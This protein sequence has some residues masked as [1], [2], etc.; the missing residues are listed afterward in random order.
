[1]SAISKILEGHQSIPSKKKNGEAAVTLVDGPFEGL[2]ISHSTA[3]AQAGYITQEIVGAHLITHPHL[4]HI[5]GF[6]V[7]TSAFGAKYPKTLAGL[8]Y[9]IEAFKTHIFN[10]VIWPNLSDENG[11]V[12]LVTYMRLVE[13]GSSALG[14]GDAI[15]YIEVVRGLGIKSFSV[16]HGNCMENHRH[17]GSSLSISQ[18]DPLPSPRGRALSTHS[19]LKSPARAD[20]TVSLTPSEL[21]REHDRVQQL[22]KDPDLVCVVDSSAYFI[23]DAATGREVLIFGDVEP[24]ALS[25]SPRNHIVWAEAAPK[26]VDG[27]LKAIFIEC[28]FD[29][30]QKDNM[31]YG[32]LAPRWMIVEMKNLAD[33]VRRVRD[34]PD[35][36][37][38][39]RNSGTTVPYRRNSKWP[40]GPVGD[41]SPSISPRTA[42]H[43][44]D[45][46]NGSHNGSHNGKNETVEFEEDGDMYP[47]SPHPLKGLKV[48]I[49][50]MKEK[51][52]D[53]PLVGEIILKELTKHEEEAKTGCEFVISK[54]GEAMYF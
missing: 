17:R 33:A 19:Q 25:L 16:S 5:S 45:F 2:Q 50:H 52:N 3:T 36:K 1:M 53:G 20:S 23:R 28:S 43:R 51:L 18:Q 12:G 9:T 22:R 13:G 31:L 24:D 8:P 26:I 11:G 47:P 4:D 40:G 7:N 38:R 32:H 48:V 41:L 44:H 6:V 10:N 34:G 29:D 21:Y 46:G 42:R 37:K 35:G 39:K 14:E 54:V 15:G 30:S 49:I 27:K